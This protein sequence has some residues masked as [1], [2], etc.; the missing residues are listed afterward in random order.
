MEE[1]HSSWQRALCKPCVDVVGRTLLPAWDSLGLCLN[2][3]LM[4][5]PNG[6]LW[7]ERLH[8]E[9][10][11]FLWTCSNLRSL[12]LESYNIELKAEHLE[13]GLQHLRS[14]AITCAVSATKVSLCLPLVIRC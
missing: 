3:C 12:V 11:R 6:V 4:P 7:G 13:A 1:T 10:L 9:S 5:K 8:S 14:A 2:P